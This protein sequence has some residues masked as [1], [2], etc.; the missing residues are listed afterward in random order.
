MTDASRCLEFGAQYPYDHGFGEDDPL[1]N[2]APTASDWAHAA[3]RGIMS[4]LLDRR[5]IRHEF[6]NVDMDVRKEIVAVMADIIR[7]AQRTALRV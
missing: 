4:D 5:G 2:P 3:A 6:G 1:T 7:T